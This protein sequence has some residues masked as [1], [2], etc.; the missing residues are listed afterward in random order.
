MTMETLPPIPYFTPAERR[1]LWLLSQGH[2]TAETQRAMGINRTPTLGTRLREKLEARTT[3]HALFKAGDLGLVGPHELCGTMPGYRRHHGRHEDACRACRRALAD[4]TERTGGMH[5][6]RRA[7]LTEPELRLLRAFDA[8]RSVKGL[9]RQWG[10]STRTLDTVRSG[11]YTKLDVRHLPDKARRAAALDEGRRQGFL[12]PDAFSAPEGPK[13]RAEKQL[14]ALEVRTLGAVSGG[15]SL[16][17]AGRIL[18]VPGPSVSSRLARIY[19]KLD[20]LHH[21]HGE[22]REAALKEARN[23]G[24]HV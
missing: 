10:C 11:L 18:G 21:A 16:S 9:A 1:Y 12:R 14:T 17:Q 6:F 22:R 15:R 7:S 5:P 24:Y 20:V 23:R 2:T 13:R 4:F 8:G 3:A 19:A